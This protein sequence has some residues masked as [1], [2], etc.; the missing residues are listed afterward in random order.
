MNPIVHFEFLKWSHGPFLS[1]TTLIS[2]V[3]Y[4]WLFQDHFTAL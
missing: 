1:T 3:I 4:N 2:L